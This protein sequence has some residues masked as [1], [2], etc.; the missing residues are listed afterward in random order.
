MLRITLVSGDA[1]FLWIMLEY[2]FLSDSYLEMENMITLRLSQAVV[3][4]TLLFPSDQGMVEW[5]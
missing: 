4:V 5:R 1:I 2:S 3:D